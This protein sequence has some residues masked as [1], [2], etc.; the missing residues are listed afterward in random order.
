MLL[1]S[2]TRDFFFVAPGA[3]LPDAP[4]RDPDPENPDDG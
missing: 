2:L 1:R 4:E 3:P